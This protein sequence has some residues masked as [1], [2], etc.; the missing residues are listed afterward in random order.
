[1]RPSTCQFSLSI[2]D[3]ELAILDYLSSIRW[4]SS[5]FNANTEDFRQR[6]AAIAAEQ[7]PVEWFVLNTEA[8]VEIDITAADMLSEF[9]DELASRDIT[10]ALARVKQDLYAQLRRSGLLEKIGTDRIY[11]TPHTAIAGFSSSTKC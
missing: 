8:I 10:F 1:L 4:A 5:N 7:V 2:L 9:C 6:A 3:F 11:L